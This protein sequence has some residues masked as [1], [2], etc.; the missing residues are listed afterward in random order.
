MDLAHEFCSPG[1]LLKIIFKCKR[2][3]LPGLA[4]QRG[5]LNGRGATTLKAQRHNFF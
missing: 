2:G 5:R 4:F 1:K 3:R